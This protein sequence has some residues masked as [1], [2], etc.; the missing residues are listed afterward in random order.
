MITVTDIITSLKF[1]VKVILLFQSHCLEIKCEL[2]NS[3]G[4]QCV[5]IFMSK[6]TRQKPSLVLSE[7]IIGYE[8]CLICHHL[9]DL[10]EFVGLFLFNCD[11]P[12]APK[13]TIFAC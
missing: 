9:Q 11:G 7:V 13:I 4:F 12:R 2:Q 3:S 5:I 10:E 8:S 1:I 6:T